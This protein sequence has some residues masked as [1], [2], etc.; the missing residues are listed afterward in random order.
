MPTYYAIIGFTLGSVLVLYQPIT[1]DFAGFIAI[2]LLVS[3][4]KLAG[5][6]EKWTRYCKELYKK[7]HAKAIFFA[8]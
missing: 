6:L 7:S 5:K 3:G 8:V 4:F 1:W 2:L